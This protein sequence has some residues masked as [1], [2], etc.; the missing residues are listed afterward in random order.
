MLPNMWRKDWYFVKKGYCRMRYVTFGQIHKHEIN[1]KVFDKDCV[2]I[3]NGNREDVLKI[4][5]VKFCFDYTKEEFDL[6]SMH[7][8]PR[9]IIKL[10][11]EI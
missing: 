5:G 1:G 3:V 7:Y 11:N 10:N 8:Y 9:G 4:F 2:A 6:N